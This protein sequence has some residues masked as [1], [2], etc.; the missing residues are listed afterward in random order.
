MWLVTGGAGFIGSHIVKH[1]VAANQPVRVLDNF[2]SGNPA[3]LDGF[4]GSVEVIE[5]DIRD[6]ALVR[7]AMDGIEIVLH[8]AAQPSVPQSMLDPVTTYAVNLTGTLN[9]LNAARD[10]TVRRVVLAS[11]S[12]VY[13]NDPTPRKSELL[14]PKPVSPYASSKLATEGLAEVFTHAYGL[15]CVALRYFNVFGPGQDPNSAYAAVIP[16]VIDLL[17]RGELP[18]I[19]GDGGQTRDFV[20]VGD[21]VEANMIAARSP[22]GPGNVYNIASGRAVTILD[23]VGTLAA[24][25]GTDAAVRHLPE[26][27][28]DIRDSLADVSKAKRDLGFIA[29]TSLEAGLAQTVGKHRVASAA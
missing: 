15:P 22:V 13:G 17:H 2:S 11:T 1:L 23:M 12:A 6:E 8:Q 18:T 19:F 3:R 25:L 9:L 24:L 28:G 16:K 10:A 5:G 29:A 4:A 20:Y 26:R 7:R 21:V 14:I 27:A